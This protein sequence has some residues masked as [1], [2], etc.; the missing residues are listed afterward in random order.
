MKKWFKLFI[1]PGMLV[2]AIAFVTLA[3]FSNIINAS[4][5][6]DSSIL[7][8]K[9]NNAA[10]LNTTSELPPVYENENL[11]FHSIEEYD[12]YLLSQSSPKKGDTQSS[13][14]TSY[15]LP[16]SLPD[17]AE[18]VSIVVSESG[19]VFTYQLDRPFELNNFETST[20]SSNLILMDSTDTTLNALCQ[21]I[22]YKIINTDNIPSS[23]TYASH[24]ADDI[25]AEPV[26]DE[27][28]NYKDIYKGTL[29]AASSVTN[30]HYIVGTQ[31]VSWA[32]T[33]DQS[34]IISK[35]GPGIILYHYYPQT[36]SASEIE[37]LLSV[38]EHNVEPTK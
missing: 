20:Y 27:C 32:A 26:T 2:L 7:D 29:Y 16:E 4:K 9:K 14:I 23:R 3:A 34:G 11:V 22:R 13:G 6:I 31:H 8:D 37:G 30:K 21:T 19:T 15:Y 24:F 1:I 10:N 38:V 28:D 12:K 18:L 25:G 36:L 5:S 33:K 35:D 17:D